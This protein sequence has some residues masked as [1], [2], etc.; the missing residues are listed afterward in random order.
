MRNNT[1]RK[2]QGVQM[3]TL[4]LSATLMFLGTLAL[5]NGATTDEQILAIKTA[6][7]TQERVTLMNEFKATLSTLSAQE[8]ATAID[9][10]RSNM[11]G[12][13][14]QTQTQVRVNER[15][16]ANQMQADGSMLRNQTANQNKAASQATGRGVATHGF[17][18][19]K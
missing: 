11:N 4:K 3:K 10:L 2:I 17:M 15:V 5:C 8:R 19:N 9:Q 12:S 14:G 13:G 16:H 1:T 18:G 7:T 6:T